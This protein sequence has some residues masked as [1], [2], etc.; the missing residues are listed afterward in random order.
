MLW[1]C[2]PEAFFFFWTQLTRAEQD[3]CKRNPDRLGTHSFAI[4]SWHTEWWR[5]IWDAAIP[6]WKQSNLYKGLLNC[7]LRFDFSVLSKVLYFL[8]LNGHIYGWHYFCPMTVSRNNRSKAANYRQKLGLWR[9]LSQII[10]HGWFNL[11]EHP[12]GNCARYSGKISYRH[13][14]NLM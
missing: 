9:K 11:R 4:T 5:W 8:L 13:G 2:W 6:S 10:D 3:S 12:P 14:F 7:C 1:S